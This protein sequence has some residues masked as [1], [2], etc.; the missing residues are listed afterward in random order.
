MAC[1][2]M[3]P[4]ISLPRILNVS[5]RLMLS[6]GF[7]SQTVPLAYDRH[8]PPTS[9]P[10]GPKPP[11]IFMHG[12]FGSKR[13]NRSISKV[14]ARDLNRTIYAV[15]LRNHGDA[16]HNEKHDYTAMAHDVEAFVQDHKLGSVSLI[17]HSM[18]AKTAL[19]VA[20]QSP[21]IVENVIAVDNAPV[22]AALRADFPNYVRGMKKVED[23]NVTKAS[24]AD[25]IMSEFEESLPV[26]QFLLSNLIR[27]PGS[28]QL[29]FRNPLSILASS[30]DNM[31][32]FPF[33]NPDE[34]RYNKP[35]LF[36]RGTRSHYIPDEVLPVIGRFFPLFELRD[37]ESGHWVISE[38]PEAF[39]QAV[40]EFLQEKE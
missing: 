35:A 25:K 4:A 38:N 30:L 15:D 29:K 3:R 20:L 6:R 5:P 40:V 9:S 21:D 18:G 22:D 16:E 23:A 7:A 1:L 8:D 2:L 14:L 12:L 39:R 19:T 11:I 32:D 27:E 10:S 28:P 33:K 26:R 17:G 37:V 36:I 24:E 34:V 31:G 13:N